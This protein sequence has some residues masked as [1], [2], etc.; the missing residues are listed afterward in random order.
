MA[1]AAV[2]G[3]GCRWGKSRSA[4][5]VAAAPVAV[6]SAAPLSEP[7]TRIRLPPPQ[8]IP[9]EAIPPEL[10]PVEPDPAVARAPEPP[11]KPAPRARP[12]ASPAPGV[13]AATTPAPSGPQLRPVFTPEQEKELHRQ[14][15]RSLASAESVLGRLRVPP[16][17]RDRQAAVE[18]VRAFLTQAREA[19]QQGDLNRARSLAERADLLAADLARTTK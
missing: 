3:M 17:D 7:Q 10:A 15:E 8:P 4:P 12:P 13:P 9:P 16:S 19:R 11:P 18:R 1:I 14:I 2:L 6:A 5:P